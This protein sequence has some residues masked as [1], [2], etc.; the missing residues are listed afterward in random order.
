[1]SALKSRDQYFHLMLVMRDALLG[2]IAISGYLYYCY[3]FG[4]PDLG[5]NDF[6]QY[7]KMV[8]HP[9]D[10]S[11][12]SAPF[13]L[14]QVPT[15]VAHLLYKYGIFYDTKANLDLILPG[16]I[17]TKKVFFSLI[18]SNTLAAAGSFTV[19]LTYIRQ[20]TQN[21]DIL[22]SFSYLGIMLSYF[23]VPFSVIAPLSYGWGWLTS[24]ILAIALLE[25]KLLTLLLGC[26][27]ALV[28]RET[29]LIFVLA[30]SV[31]T[32]GSFG[33]MDRFYLWA[34]IVAAL[35][36]AVLILARTYIVH[37]HEDQIDVQNLVANIFL[38][39]PTRE[40]MFQSVIPQVLIAVL[41][42]SLSAR[43]SLYALALF[44]S[45]IAV[46]I[47]SIGTGITSTGRVIG[48]T[49][50]FYAIIFLLANL[51]GLVAVQARPIQEV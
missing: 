24:T 23:F 5:N 46:M 17:E 44:L 35:S 19:A 6:Y 21:N 27:L 42:M 2:F 15:F 32:W 39:R 43:H 4:T 14:R 13:V 38:F 8:E 20:K 30:F 25:K 26:L 10:L 48:E 34:A 40:F 47:V 12:T 11:V 45:T 16:A 22:I 37:G 18:L 1:M 49:L 29:I 7:Q 3:K 36:S 9:F 51:G 41:V 28:T 50:P 33:R 31:F